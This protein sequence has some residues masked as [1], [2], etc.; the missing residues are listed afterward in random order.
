MLALDK[1]AVVIKQKRKHKRYIMETEQS[2]F[3]NRIDVVEW[4]RKYKM[5]SVE[6]KDMNKLS[7]S[8]FKNKRI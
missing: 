1:M 4:D 5:Q 7:T 6:G 8:C 3:L 2:T